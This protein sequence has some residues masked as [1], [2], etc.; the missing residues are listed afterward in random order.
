LKKEIELIG[1]IYIFMCICMICMYVSNE[2]IYVYTY[3]Y[4]Y[5]YIDVCVTKS[6][7]ALK[8]EIELIGNIYVSMNHI[9]T[10]LYA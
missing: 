8:K 2:Y 6:V 5:I 4:I 1:I 3:I 7:E 10:C 9:C